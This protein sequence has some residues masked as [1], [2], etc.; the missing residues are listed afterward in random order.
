MFL[1]SSVSLTYQ[2]VVESPSDLVIGNIT[3][4][5]ILSGALN[6]VDLFSV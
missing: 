1:D 2:Y 3:N 5:T 4:N 6:M